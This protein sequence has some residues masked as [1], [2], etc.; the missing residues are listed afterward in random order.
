M[1]LRQ[2][3]AAHR[4]MGKIEA[5]AFTIDEKNAASLMDAVEVLDDVLINLEGVLEDG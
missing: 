3:M 4:A 2:M 5:V 1:T